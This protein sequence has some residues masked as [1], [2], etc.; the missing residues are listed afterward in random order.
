MNTRSRCVLAALTLLAGLSAAANGQVALPPQPEGVPWPTAEWQTAALPEEVDEAAL[1][2]AMDEAFKVSRPELGETRELVIIHRGQL[3]YE[4]YAS[5]YSKDTRLVSWSM[6][7]SITQALVGI[8]V[9]Q[10]RI[11]IDAPMG[12]PRWSS[13]D[14]RARIPWRTWLQMTDGQRYLEIEAPSMAQSDASRKLFG[15]GRLDVASYCAALPLVHEPGTTWN[16]NSCGIVLT[17]DAL[18][19]TIIPEPESA[20]ARRAAMLAWMRENLFDV[21]GMQ[22]QPEFDAAGLYY[23]SALIYGSARDFAKFGLLYLR[24]GVWQ[25]QRVLPEGWVD[26]ARTP[27]PGRNAD[28]YGAGWWVSPQQG[29]GR[30]YAA[31]MQ[32]GELRDAFWAQGFEGQFTVVVPAKDLVIVRLGRIGE[33]PEQWAAVYDW[34]GRLAQAFPASAE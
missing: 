5:G 27:G 25:G 15:P 11:G 30:P 6:A 33:D 24:D 17:A 10:G 34:L 31:L 12:N 26:F 16:Y 1:Q 14:P 21:L 28:I 18:T 23:G 32:T 8:A 29:S 19:R 20:E 2:S 13:E 22:V 7:K 9:R 4:Q 3:V